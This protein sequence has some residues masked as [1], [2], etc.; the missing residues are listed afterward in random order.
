MELFP[1]PRFY[2]T[3]K[4][5]KLVDAFVDAVSKSFSGKQDRTFNRVFKISIG[6]R[7]CYIQNNWEDMQHIPSMIIHVTAGGGVD[8]PPK[9][10]PQ[11]VLQFNENIFPEKV[12][13]DVHFLSFPNMTHQFIH[14]AMSYTMIYHDCFPF[15][16]HTRGELKHDVV[17]LLKRVFR[18]LD[19]DFDGK[20]QVSDFSKY[21]ERY[22]G[23]EL[24]PQDMLLMFKALHDGSEPLNI[25]TFVQSS[26]N[27]EQFL[28]IMQYY[29]SL[30]YGHV[31]LQIIRGA[32]Y[33]YFFND[34]VEM[35]Q[36]IFLN[37]D[38]PAIQGHAI[39]FLHNVYADFGLDNVLEQVA[40]EFRFS[41]DVP[42]RFKNV[43]E[44]GEETWITKWKE[45][46]AIDPYET[47]RTL[48]AFGYPH[49]LILDAF[50]LKKPESS[51]SI[52]IIAGLATAAISIG[53]AWFLFRRK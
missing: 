38:P 35:S 4:D 27:F 3:G 14:S 28:K 17:M 36:T 11:I 2:A 34:S 48:L 10:L 20:I 50:G 33:Y 46:S 29:V 37:M 43:R 31:I 8:L 51:K 49:D 5:Q 39:T 24:G 42:E 13:N 44:M 18:T 21:H 6:N 47:A 1:V 7:F 15:S 32:D 40:E 26:L 41:G 52:P 30:G 23:T 16:L 53:G 19:T 45:W 9:N 12:E 22:L 25:Y